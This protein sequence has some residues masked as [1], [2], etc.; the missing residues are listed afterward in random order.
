MATKIAI[1]G[2]TGFIGRHLIKKLLSEGF[3]QIKTLTRSS[4]GAELLKSL[5]TEP[6][7]GDVLDKGSLS[8]LVKEAEVIFHLAGVVSVSSAIKNPE[9][10]F[11]VNTVGTLNLLEAVRL[12]NTECFIIFLSSDRVY[13]CPQVDK[14]NET[15]PIFPIDPYGAT[16]ASAEH[17]CQA[18]YRTYGITFI[19][20]RGASTYGPEQQSE[21]LIPSLIQKL[22][23]GEEE[24]RVGNLEVYRNFVYI[25][26]LVNALYL[27][28]L[29]KEKIK[30]EIFNVSESSV[31]VSTVVEILLN[32]SS[33]YLRRKP[34]LIQ[35]PS[36]ARKCEMFDKK[37][38]L[39]CSKIFKILNWKP[40]FSLGEGLERTFKSFWG[41]YD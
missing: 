1:T 35:D 37:W 5:G 25:E 15:Y 24:I 34:W 39:D 26:D 32:L 8:D 4:E 28:F 29:S 17:L 11:L 33:K 3:F 2:G 14:V 27:A 10:S 36:L 31:K 12:M 30:G 18:Y 6:I 16:K 19:I 20:L 7:Y 22:V 40:Q 21:L 38:E 9:R 23:G 41:R 13:G